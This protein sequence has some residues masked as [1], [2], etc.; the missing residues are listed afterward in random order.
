ME[1]ENVIHKI[2]SW[3]GYMPIE[4]IDLFICVC[5]HCNRAFVETM[6]Q[7]ICSKHVS[8]HYTYVGYKIF[9]LGKMERKKWMEYCLFVFAQYA[10]ESFLRKFVMQN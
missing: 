4:E 10:T 3:N 9:P 8:T 2:W 7:T 1:R 5:K 6:H